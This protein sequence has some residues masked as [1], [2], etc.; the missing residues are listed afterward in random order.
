MISFEDEF[1][2]VETGA[3]VHFRNLTLLPLMRPDVDSED[4]GYL[5]LDEAIAQGVASVRELGGAGSVPE[6]EFDNRAERPVLLVDGQELIGAKQN[7][8]LNL[9][10][11]VP[12][13]TK[14]TIPVSCVEAGRWAYRSP[15]FKPAGHMMYSA[16]R[17]SRVEQVTSSMRRTGSRRSDQMEVWEDIALKAARMGVS[18][19]TQAMAEI[20]ERHSISVEEYVR[21]FPWQDRQA[22]TVFAIGGHPVGFDLFDHPATLRKLLPSLVRSYALDAL[23]FGGATCEAAAPQAMAELLAQAAAA[24]SFSDT[25]VG[26]GKDVRLVGPTLRGAALWAEDRYVHVCA[27]VNGSD[28]ARGSISSRVSRPAQRRLRRS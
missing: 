5:V 11:L 9:T 2:R 21:A 22:G 13:K 16:A 8:V 7:R 24:S 28:P 25:A 20:F 26:L 23:D 3:P 6:L 15:D 19:P 27:F 17:A 12:A 1:R 10:I 4:P 14:L 18:S